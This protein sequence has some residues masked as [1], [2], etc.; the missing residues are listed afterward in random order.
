[1]SYNRKTC[2]YCNGNHAILDCAKLVEDAKKAQEKL[3]EIENNTEAWL[4]DAV[5]AH[6]KS[7]FHY[8]LR[9]SSNPNGD[10]YI[11]KYD[12]SEKTKKM[13]VDRTVAT[14]IWRL[15]GHFASK[16]EARN[17][18][19]P[20]L[21]D[22]FPTVLTYEERWNGRHAYDEYRPDYLHGIIRRHKDVQE[23][24]SKR[25]KKSCSYCRVEGHTV[26]TCPQKKLDVEIYRN[27]YKISAYLSAKAMSRFGLWT[28]SMIKNG[29]QLYSFKPTHFQPF[30]LTDISGNAKISTEDLT[31][32][33][34]FLAQTERNNFYRLGADSYYGNRA[35]FGAEVSKEYLKML[36]LE[37]NRIDLTVKEGDK[38]LGSLPSTFLP[39]AI[40]TEHI[41][42]QLME[43]YKEPQPNKDRYSSP[44]FGMGSCRSLFEETT[45]RSHVWISGQDLFDRKKRQQNTFEQMTKFIATHKDILEKANDVLNKS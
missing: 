23:A 30:M 44:E 26:R 25:A 20:D 29:D 1:M 16:E 6:Q 36:D 24:V 8:E 18:V 40:D 4:K 37:N 31:D 17:A 10:G 38:Q 35:R 9:H 27:A 15:A 41:F 19:D 33:L 7:A 2:A 12:G 14:L 34:Y 45:W 28:S 22:H 42:K 3:K 13:L 21:F 5:V 43:H 11:V 39:V 32:C